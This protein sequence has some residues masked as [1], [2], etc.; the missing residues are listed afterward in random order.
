MD[1]FLAQARSLR[2]EQLERTADKMGLAVG[3][4]E[5]DFWVCWVL[6]ELFHSAAGP[7]LTFK[8]GTSLSKCW[9]LIERFS[10]DVDL[11]VD[12]DALGFAGDAAPEAAKSRKERERRVRRVLEACKQHVQELLHPMLVKIARAKLGDAHGHAVILDP[13]DVDQQT[14]LFTYEPIVGSKSY[15]RPVVK[16]EFGARSDTEPNQVRTIS[17]YVSA[18]LSLVVG[19]SAFTVRAVDAERTFWEKVSLLHEEAYRASSPRTRLARHYYDLW[20]LDQKGIGA[21]ALGEPLLFHRV[22]EHRRLFFRANAEAQRS[23]KP[24][25]VRLVPSVDRMQAWRSDLNAMRDS[26]FFGEPPS[27][28]EIV[29]RMSALEKR[30]NAMARVGE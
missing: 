20:C 13:D 14:I 15:L 10:E 2:T 16:M 30:I 22:V 7:R 23:L 27:F 18:V 29:L 3:A 12:R 17:P 8:G 21:A 19:D 26:M 4:I 28:D 9:G 6:K 5:K 25:T 24:G 1:A 11:V